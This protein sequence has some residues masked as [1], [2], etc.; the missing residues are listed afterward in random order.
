MA[1]CEGVSA[2]DVLRRLSMHLDGLAADVHAIEHAI[3]EES[4]RNPVAHNS[5]IKRLQ[6]LDFLRQSLEDLALLNLFLADHVSG[7]LSSSL[8][9]SLRLAST[10]A[11][12]NPDAREPETSISNACIGDLDLF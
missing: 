6:R 10:K 2:Q 3:G 11:L 4:G 12:L 5:Y 1:N 9:Q 8:G 7:T